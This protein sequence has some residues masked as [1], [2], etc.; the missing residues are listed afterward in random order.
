MASEEAHH[1][2]D[3]VEAH[4]LTRGELGSATNADRGA[5]SS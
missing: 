4:L 1:A 2:L 3:G 5:C